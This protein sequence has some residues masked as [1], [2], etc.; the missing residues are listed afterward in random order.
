MTQIS[1]F[2]VANPK[3]IYGIDYFKELTTK[4]NKMEIYFLDDFVG[5]LD[6]S[7]KTES[8]IENEIL[9]EYFITK[10]K[11]D[12]YHCDPEDMFDF[13]DNIDRD[14]IKQ[15]NGFDS[16]FLIFI[17]NKITE[18]TNYYDEYSLFNDGVLLSELCHFKYEHIV[19]QFKDDKKRK[20]MNSFR[21]KFIELYKK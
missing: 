10:V 15:I 14:I 13:L 18:L 19:K 17:I 2:E 16:K 9:F 3:V 11:N 5:V 4:G 12:L 6:Y 8:K 7:K 21:N 20:R 1:M